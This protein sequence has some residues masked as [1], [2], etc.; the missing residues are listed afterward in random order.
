MLHP[1]THLEE[2]GLEDEEIG[3]GLEEMGLEEEFGLTVD[4]G[5]SNLRGFVIIKTSWKLY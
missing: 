5:V 3:L 4:E 1:D 2:T